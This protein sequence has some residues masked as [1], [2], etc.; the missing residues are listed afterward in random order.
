MILYSF[1]VLCSQNIPTDMNEDI[2]KKIQQMY[3]VGHT[4]TREI[5]KILKDGKK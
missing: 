4:K 2:K 5:N 1:L 3:Q